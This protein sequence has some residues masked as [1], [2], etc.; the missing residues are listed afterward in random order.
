MVNKVR[1]LD[2]LPEVFR[3]PT[4]SQ[5]LSASLD[6]LT[7]QP[8]LKR[9]EGFI[10]NKFGYGIEPNDRYVVEPTKTRTDY[11]LDPSVVFLK[12]DTQE[13][14]DFINYPGIIRALENEGAV[15]NNHDRMWS[16]DFY[17]WDSFVD[18]DKIVNYNQYYWIPNGPDAVNVIPIDIFFRQNYSPIINQ[19]G[20]KY[21]NLPGTNPIITLLRGGT[22]VF[23]VEEDSKFWIQ[24]A[25][26]LSGYGSQKNLST[27]DIL[28]VT[29]NGATA[30]EIVF[31]VPQKNAQAQYDI[32]GNLTV[33]LVTTLSYSEVTDPSSPPTNID[34]ITQLNGKTLLFYN[35]DATGTNNSNFYTISQ[36]VTGG[37]ITLTPAVNPIPLEQKITANSGVQWVGRQFFLAL[38]NSLPVI[39]IIPYLSAIQ[40]TLYYQDGTNPNG[41]GI[42]KLVE[43][44]E[45]NVIDVDD[46]IG[47]KNYVSPNG[48]EFINGL[49]VKFGPK[50]T[51]SN[52]REQSYYIEGVG[53]SIT[54]LPVD[55]YIAYEE[56][57]ESLY[58]PWDITLWDELG[59]SEITGVALTPDYLTINRNSRDLN[60]WTRSNRWFNQQVIDATV[61][62]NGQL[63]TLAFNVPSKAARPIVEFQGNLHL[64][65]SGTQCAGIVDLI[66]WGDPDGSGGYTS[67]TNALKNVVGS[68]QYTTSNGVPLTPGFK[69][70]FPRDINPEVRK[71]IYT[72]QFTP[73]SSGEQTILLVPT[74]ENIS[75]GSQ[76]YCK[77]GG[78]D[79]IVGVKAAGIALKLE[80]LDWLEAQ[81]KTEI[82]QK[83]LYDIFDENGV[84]FGNP[85]V[86]FNTTFAGTPLFSY[87]PGTGANDPILGFPVK[88][89]SVTNIGDINFTVNLN[90]DSF[91]YTVSQLDTS[92][93][94]TDPITNGFVHWEPQAGTML[95]RNGWIQAAD[96]SF[97]YQVFNFTTTATS[98]VEFFCDIPA[99]PQT[100]TPWSTS[101]VYVDDRILDNTEYE[102]LI[103]TVKATTEVVLKSPVPTNTKVTVLIYSDAVS[104][105]AYYQV[106][107]NLQSN[108]FNTNIESVDLGD[109]RNHYRTIFGNTPGVSGR[110]FGSNNLYNLGAVAKYGTAIIQ[111]SASL[112]LPGVFLRKPGFNL[113]EALRFNSDQYISY[114]QQLV[115]LTTKND[116]SIYQTPAEMLDAVIYQ[117]GSNKNQSDSFYWSDMLP[118][119]SAYRVNTYSFN[120][121]LSTVSF[122]LGRIY[123]FTSSNFWGLGIYVSRTAGGRTVTKQLVQGTDYQ[124]ITD[125]PGVTVTYDIIPGDVFTVKEYNQTY[126]S[127]C[128]NTPTK[129]GLYSST[130]PSVYLDNTYKTPTYFIVGHDGSYTKLYGEYDPVTG[131]LN[132]FRDQVL[133]E[134][135]LRVYNNLK[136]KSAI[137][138]TMDDVFPGQFR[139]TMY[140]RSEILG[141]YSTRFLAWIGANRIDYKQQQFDATNKFTY[142]YNQTSNRENGLQIEQGYWRGVYN[143]FYDTSNPANAPWEM[144]GFT[145]QPSWWTARYGAAP[146]TCDNLFMWQDIA[147]GYVWNNGNSY[148]EPNRV[149]TGLLDVIPVD[150]AGNLIAPLDSVVDNYLATTFN[151]NWIVGDQAPAETSYL[152]SSSWPFDLMRILA[153]TRPSEFFNLFV[154]RDLYK[155]D[156]SMQQYLYDNRYH[157]DPRDI[158]VYGNG[159]SKA[160][161]INWVVDY[162]NQRGVNGTDSVTTTLRNIDVR[163]TYNLAG[164]SAKNYLKFLI[165]KSTP[166]TQN[167]SLLIPDNSY[168]VLLYDNPA[169]ERITYSSVIAQR[170]ERGWAVYGN[171]Q[172]QNYFT[173]TI[174]KPGTTDTI[175]VGSASIKVSSGY[176]P[177]KQQI[178][179]YGTQFYSLQ[180]VG[181]FLINYGRYLSDQ[182]VLFNNVVGGIAYD[183]QQMVKE[184]LYWAQQGWENGSTISLNPDA[185]EITV[186]KEGLVVQPLTVQ[187]QNFI[188]NQNLLPL[189]RQNVA[190]I[191]ENSS[192]TVKV[193]SEGDTVA[194]T[195]LNLSS[196]EHAV[197]FDNSTVFNDTIYNLTTGLRQSRL[198][199]SGYKTAEWNGFINASGFILNQDNVAEWQPNVKYAKGQIVTYKGQYW[200]ARQLIEPSAE[201]FSELWVATDYDKIKSGLLPNPSTQAYESLYYYDSYRAN[202]ENDADLLSFSLIG[203]RPRQYLAD[204]D[205]SDITQINV[206]KN[207]I[208]SKGTNMI[209]NAFKNAD[210]LQGQIDYDLKENW[211]VK[212]GDFGGTLNSNFVEFLVSQSQLKGN[213]ALIGFAQDGAQVPGCQFTVQLKEL[214]NYSRPPLSANFLPPY[215]GSYRWERGLPSAGYVNT[216]DAK[217]K[218]FE[219]LDLNDDISNIRNF[220]RGDVIWVAKYKNSWDVFSPQ[221]LNTQLVEV[222]N[223]LNGTVVLNFATPHGLSK[224]DPF[225]VISFS[226]SIDG[227]Y[228]V[229]TVN[230]LN[231]LTV[232]LIL[233]PTVTVVA[234]TSGVFK[235]ISR[236][237]E[238]AS[239]Q[240]SRFIPDSQY[241]TTLNWVD[242]TDG[243]NQWTVWQDSP[244]FKQ[245]NTVQPFTRR[246]GTSVAYSVEAGLIVT[247]AAG[248]VYRNGF[249]TGTTAGAG[250]QL[251]VKT[252]TVYISSPANSQVIIYKV[253]DDEWVSDSI[254]SVSNTGAIAVGIDNGQTWLFCGNSS[255]NQV[256]Y[257]IIGTAFATITGPINSR[258]G[259]SIATSQDGIKLIVGAPGMTVNGVTNA[260][261]AYIY[262]RISS[263]I[264]LTSVEHSTVPENGAQFG[265]SVAT[266]RYGAE[267]LIGA[268]YERRDAKNNSGEGAVYRYTNSG[269]HYGIVYG[270]ITGATSTSLTIWIDNIQYTVPAG[271]TAA[272]FADFINGLINTNLLATAD[273]ETFTITTRPGTIDTPWDIIDFVAT[274]Q[275]LATLGIILCINTQVITSPNPQSPSEFGRAIAIGEDD[276]VAISAPTAAGQLETTFDFT[277]NLVSDDTIFDNGSTIFVDSFV[278]SG[279]VFEYDYLPAYKESVVNPGKWIFGQNIQ[280][281]TENNR[282]AQTLMGAAVAVNDGVIAVGMPGWTTAFGGNTGRATVFVSETGLPS[283]TVNKQPLTMVDVNGLN[284]IQLYDIETNE[285]LDYVDYIDPLQGKLLGAVET[286]IDVISPLDPANY[287]SGI[288]WGATQIGKTWLDTS[289]LRL[290]N[291]NQPSISYDSAKWGAAFPGSTADIYTWVAYPQPPENYVGPGFVVDFEKYTRSETLNRSTNS[292]MTEYYFWVK[293]Y[294]EIPPGKTLSPVTVS[295]YVLN[296]ISSGISF[297]AAV[298]TNVV[299]LYNSQSS[300]DANSTVVHIGYGDTGIDS[301]QIHSNWGLVQENNSDDFLNGLPVKPEDQPSG[302][303]LKYLY[304][305][306]GQ[307]PN[308]L[309]VPDPQLPPLARWGTLFRPRQSMF[310]DR[311]TAL[312]NYVQYANNVL[313]EYPIVEIRGIGFLEN[314]KSITISS[315]N[316][317]S[318]ITVDT[319]SGVYANQPIV[320][321]GI[322][323]GG[324]KPN[325]TYYIK[326]VV[327]STI[328]LSA[329]RGGPLL[330]LTVDTGS[331]VGKLWDT[332][333]YWKKVDWWA[334]GY[335]SDTKIILEVPA[336][337]DLV[338]LSSGATST[339]AGGAFVSV[340]NGLVARVAANRQNN[341]ETWVYND[342]T[343]TRIGLTN[344]TIELLDTIYT[345]PATGMPVQWIVRWLNEVVYT[346][347]IKIYRNR[348]LILMFNYIQS[349]SLE[350]QN[351]LPW[352]NK[353]SLVDVSHRV[354]GLIQYKKFQ[355]DNQEFLAG[356][357]EEV[358]PYHVLI[359]DFSFIYDGLDFYDGNV[360]DFDLPAQYNISTGDFESP[361]LVYEPSYVPSQYVMNLTGTGTISVAYNNI[362]V[363][364][365]N[366]KFLTDITPGTTFIYNSDRRLIGKVVSVSSD[367]LMTL[368]SPSSSDIIDINWQYTN[369]LWQQQQYSQWFANYG[370]TLSGS[371]VESTVATVLSEA[372]PPNVFTASVITTTGLPQTANILIGSEQITYTS[373]DRVNNKLLGL[374][375]GENGTD[376][377]LHPVGSEIIISPAPVI[378]LDQAR[379]YVNPPRVTAV[380]DTDK[381]PYPRVEA[382]LSAVLV[383]DRVV[384]VTTVNP[385][386][387]YA[388]QPQIRIDS[389]IIETFTS[390]AVN[391]VSN[392]I[393]IPAHRFITG[394]PVVYSRGIDTVSPGGLTDW[395]YYYVYVVDANTVA[396]YFNYN[397]VATADERVIPVG[398]IEL[399][400]TGSGANHRLGV[401][402]RA[403]CFTVSQPVREF[404]INLGFDRVSYGSSIEEWRAST[405]YASRYIALPDTVPPIINIVYARSTLED[406]TLTL[407]TAT[408]VLKT[409][410]INGL[411]II[412]TRGA[413]SR[414]Y[415][416]GAVTDTVIKLYTNQSLLYPVSSSEFNWYGSQTGGF[417][418]IS[419][420]TPI[421]VDASLVMNG[422]RLWRCTTSNSD[423]V[424]TVTNWQQI[425]GTDELLTA[426]DRVAAFYRPTASMPGK[427]L[428][429]LSTGVEYPLATFQGPSFNYHALWDVNAWDATGWDAPPNTSDFYDTVLDGTSAVTSIY[430]VSGGRFDEGYGPEELVPGVVVDSLNMYYGSGEVDQISFKTFRFRADIV[431]GVISFADKTINP[432]TL[433][434]YD[435]S[436][437]LSTDN[438]I[439]QLSG[440][441]G[442]NFT[443]DWVNK[444]ITLAPGAP[445]VI[446][447]VLYGYGGNGQIVND[448]TDQYPFR[449]V[450][451]GGTIHSEIWVDVRFDFISPSESG[452]FLN[453]QELV[454]GVDYT[455]VSADPLDPGAYTH[456][457]FT[458]AYDPLT[459]YASF[460]LVGDISSGYSIPVVQDL[461]GNADP[462]HVYP[463]TGFF[464]GNNIRNAI[465]E[466]DGVRLIPSQS[467]SETYSKT[468][469]QSYLIETD[470][471]T[472]GIP[473]DPTKVRV[474][475]L[476][477]GAYVEV[478][479]SPTTWSMNW[480]ESTSTVTG[481]DDEFYAAAPT[482][483]SG[484]IDSGVTI[485]STDNY[486]VFDPTY[487][488]TI[489]T[490]ADAIKI[491]YDASAIGPYTISIGSSASN[492]SVVFNGQGDLSGR[493]VSVTSFNRDDLQSVVTQSITIETVGESKFVIEQPAFTLTNPNKLWVSV[494][495][496]T[497]G[498]FYIPPQYMAIQVSPVKNTL[499][500]T[501]PAG[502]QLQPDDVII[503]TST[504]QTLGTTD[505]ADSV[506]FRLNVDKAGVSKIFNTN[507]STRTVLTQTTWSTGRMDDRLYVA[508][509]ERLVEFGTYTGIAVVGNK[510]TIPGVVTK[511][512]ITMIAVSQGSTQINYTNIK[513]VKSAGG[514]NLEIT[515]A[516]PTTGLV[517]ITL[518]YGSKAVIQS[519]QI[520]FREIV[521]DDKTTFTGPGY[522]TGLTR[523]QNTTITNPVFLQDAVIRSVLQRDVLP[524]EFYNSTW[525][526]IAGASLEDQTTEAALFLKQWFP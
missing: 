70:L 211:A 461:L 394:D 27:R 271:V 486:V 420:P 328:T 180:G 231:S 446:D 50:T 497:G 284:S 470:V 325:V 482:E 292:L 415:Y 268:P 353:T 302:I 20:F 203:Y 423:A 189:Q 455:I 380:I 11:Q 162:I 448:N 132:D 270:S 47:S 347:E 85:L 501:L 297:L 127:Y 378:I 139:D 201:F 188:L 251:V 117:I 178:V 216:N 191:R 141:E 126:G 334:P 424:F 428:G 416:A 439:T 6:L 156:A 230:S 326:S 56:S 426:A 259:E 526:N 219:L 306:A 142:N 242:N 490:T 196:I 148:I 177:K 471:V 279:A 371:E 372:L 227:F 122:T 360:T 34:G 64:W 96:K 385:G 483:P 2:F 445:S 19:D 265:T 86:Y 161:Y 456:I 512:I 256:S 146:Y 208:R 113:F 320:F 99:V 285:T 82:N 195:N 474:Y 290:L 206:Y 390:D 370:L 275:T 144:L 276:T 213:P 153:L 506:Y 244:V 229:K 220:Y 71:T 129:L 511:K 362:T 130:R 273:G 243:T 63:S 491:T 414:T 105:T 154:D 294:S 236:R 313:A 121:F 519:E 17:A 72:V 111:N 77:Y 215:S 441:G 524:E 24:G 523:G 124:L 136:I 46:I 450:N 237:F 403:A 350:Q 267:I 274:E 166:N 343:W 336:Y 332:R 199:L 329:T 391:T 459:N 94:V 469:D 280:V 79:K 354:R 12:E 473:F 303:Y 467:Y 495:K 352:L 419:V 513:I 409:G 515:L 218:T 200:A 333:D 398:R 257:G 356:Y 508:D 264:V 150:S 500:I 305:F 447:V 337:S 300:I 517:N 134:F 14:R 186:L 84:S 98:T 440:T 45:L 135:E 112:V 346:D 170:T 388:V 61:K 386:S 93:K 478:L 66:S 81:L 37:A 412:V 364:G 411:P 323:F 433:V 310:V 301:D 452:V 344:G 502:S 51:P 402:A 382:E 151:R 143:W 322:P 123:D 406:V 317:Q 145:D 479:A 496:S 106:P 217:F 355:R 202:L 376:Q 345:Q 49:K 304:S 472:S 278:N 41:V 521:F 38:E 451:T 183:W 321:S 335:S 91:T 165:E 288:I 358:K 21:S 476:T 262:S 520:G 432:T 89:S 87:T 52:Y 137:P 249:E 489:P 466:I 307:E 176:Y 253:I 69:V 417:G 444:T 128:P 240:G 401:T 225:A 315:V 147:R 283:W 119:G 40:D 16:S 266:N 442:S 95:K 245:T 88:Y 340:E 348:S 115:D 163:L 396:L 133:L 44:N 341:S 272:T 518:A 5:F 104:E 210:L 384:G 1:T 299:A 140:S 363:L 488:G 223:N 13:A 430:D 351:Y 110:I 10:G 9:V 214:I 431:G 238:Q 392:T 319:V 418:N 159:T 493:V 109:I 383:A 475:I 108:P 252:D 367:T 286:N 458:Q 410:Q 314:G 509:A 437:P 246:Y 125:A 250:A 507:P 31:T 454:N 316:S 510:I 357:L 308:G 73:A 413:E 232:D 228:I 36:S 373:L 241:Y 465:V 187:Q 171:S 254:V 55:N 194:Y 393:T 449:T 504:R 400:T 192:F 190:V 152:R 90:T 233:D 269:Q 460:V 485:D 453:G 33:D 25:P 312:Q 368:Q 48:V 499:N 427:D 379:G 207:I 234:G 181:E 407:D 395:K 397:D 457:A 282:G 221:T 477:D 311:A 331:M 204:A 327:L 293:S 339:A 330:E 525:Y 492:A 503:I 462:S 167:T 131:H 481:L 324:I 179:P 484:Y 60:A 101:Q 3:T 291:Y 75:T 172:E 498:G 54:L 74:V 365:K 29:N 97:Q 226:D 67:G 443:V 205:L 377:E 309:L 281:N 116:F 318:Q 23:T 120:V 263:G 42:I 295:G 174:P 155:F 160:S 26:G 15:V 39:R 62:Y 32:S 118:S 289:N 349:E 399:L 369:P 65:N 114:K 522:I 102:L 222:V 494:V 80:L 247:D 182:G 103:D 35:N 100:T 359:K 168:T 438:R 421:Y 212:T 158:V 389:S 184:F 30:G 381:F 258:W 405:N 107:E 198:L 43:N 514:K 28:G 57:G 58:I 169:A 422:G 78:V 175:T 209:V 59:W 53:E 342:S 138:L 224:N 425:T 197:V 338:K 164:F 505:A 18:L 83:P 7:N 260:G 149:R 516:T 255:T 434:L 374:I 404:T 298:T 4:N 185:T 480:D 429:Q 173:T 468:T 464:G 436:N 68:A 235:L 193:L 8:D 375:R 239:D 248:R 287:T 366:T 277:D 463:L 387:G 408:S 435:V 296:P 487:F 22:Y 261:A 361:E 76:V 92:D 157:L